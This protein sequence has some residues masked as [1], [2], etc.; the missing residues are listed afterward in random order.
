MSHIQLKNVPDTVYA[1]LRERART[2]NV[3]IRD[4]V[5]R[6]IERDQ[7]RPSKADW[8]RRVHQLVPIP[9]DAAEA[10]RADRD[11]RDRDLDGR[12]RST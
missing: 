12:S 6:L 8:L 9:G 4:Y 3:T 1:E 7:S 5:L 10:L 11:E 2:D